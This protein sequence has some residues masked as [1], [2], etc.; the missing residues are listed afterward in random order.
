MD[1]Q[2]DNGA[3]RNS[4]F[5]SLFGGEGLG[6]SVEDEL[7]KDRP[8]ASVASAAE[9][10]EVPGPLDLKRA[11]SFRTVG[12]LFFHH[13]SDGISEE[14]VYRS[15]GGGICAIDFAS[16]STAAEQHLL[17]YGHQ[18]Q[19]FTPQAL[20]RLRS[21]GQHFA[22]VHAFC[23]AKSSGACGE[24]LV[25][26][27]EKALKKAGVCF[28]AF[29]K[30]APNRFFNNQ[31][32][33]A[34]ACKHGSTRFD[35][36]IFALPVAEQAQ[37]K[38]S[39]E[40]QPKFI[41]ELQR[42]SSTGCYEWSNLV[43]TVMDT[44]KGS[45]LGGAGYFGYAAL[46]EQVETT[47]SL[48]DL[49]EDDDALP[50]VD[51]KV[52]ANEY[53]RILGAICD[54]ATSF[55][56]KIQ[57]AQLLVGIS[58]CESGSQALLDVGALAIL[59]QAL[60]AELLRGCR[61]GDLNCALCKTLANLAENSNDSS[62][63]GVVVTMT[64]LRTGS[65]D[66]IEAEQL[67]QAAKALVAFCKRLHAASELLPLVRDTAARCGASNDEVLQEHSRQLL[68]NLAVVC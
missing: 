57:L 8:D 53:Q 37:L 7:M 27:A 48:L 10:F 44:L 40:E 45:C 31:S 25:A 32:S 6:L 42:L 38:Q 14:D 16:Q 19:D 13:G 51:P 56:N 17:G 47:V 1:Q 63:L 33:S 29:G 23:G 30:S 41:I 55:E 39:M 46:E 22:P 18:K 4:D 52:L 9:A 26:K 62:D 11:E 3:F 61:E 50:Q 20:P 15:V 58:A 2:T 68:Q 64:V 34:F 60:Q 67:R 28:G 24:L 65:T 21:S 59:T 12:D 43:R 36:Y 35:L 66:P 5:Q 49:T 54:D